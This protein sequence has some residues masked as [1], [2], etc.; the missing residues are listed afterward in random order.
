MT[1]LLLLITQPIN[2]FSL[3]NILTFADHLYAQE[4]YAAALN[5]Y[6]RYQFLTDSIRSDIPEKII[7][8]LIELKRYDEALVE[9][10]NI[11]DKLQK[12]FIR[13]TIFFAAQQYDSSR[14]HVFEIGEPYSA[15]AK[16]IIGLSYAYEFRF[17][18]ADQFLKLPL[19]RPKYKKPVLGAICALVPGGGHWYCGRF[20][21]GMFSF[22]LI[23]TSA[24]LS[25][26]YHHENEDIKYGICLGATGLFYIANIYGGINAVHNYNYYQNERYLEEIIDNN[27]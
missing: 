17:S 2:T 24:L 25:Y 26:Y 15:D 7:D 22:F 13:G 19:D 21:D 4:D 10:N 16:R 20:G 9:C 12:E 23:G 6:R 27:K 18:E 5:E 14:I 11:E 1:L 8:C 3:D